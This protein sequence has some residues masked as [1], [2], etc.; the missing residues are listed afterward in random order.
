MGLKVIT[1][2]ERYEIEPDDICCFLAGGITE[3]EDWQKHV[4]NYLK[5]CYCSI[6]GTNLVIFNP[7]RPKGAEP[8]G[9]IA[10]EEQIEWEFNYL[11][12]CDIFSM[13]FPGGDHKREI[14]MY[15]LGR[16]LAQGGGVLRSVISIEPN[17]KRTLD[18]QIQS[19]LVLGVDIVK[20]DMNPALHGK[21]IYDRYKWMCRNNNGY[22][23]RGGK[24]RYAEYRH[25]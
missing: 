24:P 20:L 13:Y 21:D 9:P 4:I 8:S 6:D 12:A 18:V 16:Q 2:P 7:R 5:C 14:C 10:I 19:K 1:A 15:E 3:C 25:R 17:Y 22:V 11:N 23:Y